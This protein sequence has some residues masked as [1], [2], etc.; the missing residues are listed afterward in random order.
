[1]R[2][3]TI[4]L[5]DFWLGL[6]EALRAHNTL[7]GW[8]LLVPYISWV[9]WTESL[10]FASPFG[11]PSTLQDGW[12]TGKYP[13][14][15]RFRWN[16]IIFYYLISEVIQYHFQYSIYRGNNKIPLSSRREKINSSLDE[17]S[18]VPE[19]NKKYS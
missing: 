9:C 11:L 8:R 1:M 7:E 13:E 5:K 6:F 14:R 3:Q 17:T 16:H 2:P 19:W 15:E 4:W 18:N 10:N 12:A